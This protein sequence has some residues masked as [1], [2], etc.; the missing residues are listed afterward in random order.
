MKEK[1]INQQQSLED[2]IFRIQK[3][4]CVNKLLN[5]H[6][7]ITMVTCKF[8]KKK[9]KA[10]I[11]CIWEIEAYQKQFKKGLILLRLFS[12]CLIYDFSKKFM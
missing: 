9:V 10:R 5:L 8:K 2:L 1:P 3:S 6:V 12:D 4:V 7:T 11:V